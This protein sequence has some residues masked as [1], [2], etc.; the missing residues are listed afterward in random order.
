MVNDHSFC[1]ELPI[2]GNVKAFGA[3]YSDHFL[4]PLLSSPQASPCSLVTVLYG[5]QRIGKSTFLAGLTEPF[6]EITRELVARNCLQTEATKDGLRYRY[7]D[8]GVLTYPGNIGA[9]HDQAKL[10][11]SSPPDYWLLDKT[12]LFPR[13]KEGRPGLD[14]I[15]HASVP[16]L[17]AA[18][19]AFLADSA[20]YETSKGTY[21]GRLH[22]F[23]GQVLTQNVDIHVYPYT[24]WDLSRIE[25]VR[26]R[27]FPAMEDIQLRCREYKGDKET[28]FISAVLL[29]D[30]GPKREAF[31]ALRTK[32]MNIFR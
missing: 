20:S 14:V 17:L 21:F 18:D 22:P 27:V 29:S 25:T 26:N 2:R 15:E 1:L 6:G 24:D 23:L 8:Q 10:M 3:V 11:S 4:K 9:T 19:V 5:P 12:H 13:R 32:A 7:A 16:H 30:E 31:S 28:R